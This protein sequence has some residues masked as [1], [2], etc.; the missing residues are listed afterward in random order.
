VRKFGLITTRSTDGTTPDVT[1]LRTGLQACG[2]QLVVK[3]D[4]QS[5]AAARSGVNTMVA[6]QDEGV[7]SVMCLC[8]RNDLVNVYMPA[9]SAQGYQP[10]WVQSSYINTD[11][12]NA[13]GGGNAPPD[14][15]AHVIGLSFR[16]KLNPKQDM[17]WYWAVKEADPTFEP[18]AASYYSAHSRYMQLSLL[19]AGI[20]LAGPELTPET[21]AQG[22]HRAQ[23]ANPG[24]GQPRYFQ[25][26]VGFQGPRHV[27][28]VDASMFWFDPQ[29]P[30]TIDP[31]VPGAICYV[32]RGRRYVLGAWPKGEPAF[33]RGPCL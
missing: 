32:D 31:S 18:P 4:D 6:L 20:Q 5:T 24:A 12:D 11:I 23:F 15:S 33:R 13:Y 29:R 9:A 2:V 8:N 26:R 27:M 28:S 25:A 7:T 10:E 14:Q 17:P 1:P 16:N 21:F 30:G 22:L 3:R 19:A